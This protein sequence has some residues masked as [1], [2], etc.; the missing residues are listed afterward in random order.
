MSYGEPRDWL[1][2]TSGTG[3]PPLLSEPTPLDDMMAGIRSLERQRG[4]NDYDGLLRRV[5]D[6]A[7]R[8][9]R[10][11]RPDIDVEAWGRV[12]TKALS[13]AH[14]M[15][16][17]REAADFVLAWNRPSPPQWLT[18]ALGVRGTT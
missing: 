16:S 6:E 2:W 8:M 9:A 18:D 5:V 1:A 12:A 13:C 3:V 4:P 14:A 11:E 10:A 7:M 15:P 17:I